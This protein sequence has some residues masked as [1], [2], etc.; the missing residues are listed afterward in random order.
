MFKI[1]PAYTNTDLPALLKVIQDSFMTVARDF[2]ITKENAPSNVTAWKVF[3]L[4]QKKI[5]LT[6]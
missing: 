4:V 5:V 2:N 1:R 3:S 6:Y